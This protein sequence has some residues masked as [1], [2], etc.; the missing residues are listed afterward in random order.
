MEKQTNVRS[1]PK[2]NPRNSPRWKLAMDNK[3]RAKEGD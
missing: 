2:T 1:I 3:G